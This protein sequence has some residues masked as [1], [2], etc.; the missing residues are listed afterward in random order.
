MPDNNVVI[1]IVE[2]QLDLREILAELL[3]YNDLA[4]DLAGSAEEALQ[5]LAQNSYAGAIIDLGL[6]HISGTELVKMIRSEPA[7]RAL[8]C[9]AMTAWHDAEMKRRAL[10]AGFNAYFSKPFVP[11]TVILELKA[12]IALS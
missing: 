8:P 7:T 1:L 2:D 9:V 4:A 12:A 10:E 3:S 5:L 11:E 6:P